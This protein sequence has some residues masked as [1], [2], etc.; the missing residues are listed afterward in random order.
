MLLDFSHTSWYV[1]GMVQARRGRKR[2]AGRQDAPEPAVDASQRERAKAETRAALIDAAMT[3]FAAHGLVA[4]S[5]DAICARAGYTRGAFYVHFRDREDLVAA[6]MERALGAFLDAIIA[7]GE[8]AHD[9]ERTVRRFEEAVG[10]IA[11][12]R[13]ARA[14]GS[15]TAATGVPFHRILE[16]CERSPAVR[17]R[18]V[19]LLGEAADR[20]A[21]AAAAGQVATSVRSDV[22]AD[23][24]GA[25]LVTLALG[26]VA[27]IEVGAA[28]DPSVARR[29]VLALLAPAR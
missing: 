29:A 14:R 5:L 28:F 6:V 24:L 13:T 21:K 23:A 25:L 8:E 26:F 9:L 7:T 11:Q 4:P 2:A 16:A 1:K 18:F 20:V 17:G 3:E 12:L 27:S 15:R 19:A 22:P 10:G